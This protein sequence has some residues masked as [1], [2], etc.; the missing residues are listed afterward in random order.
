V[1]VHDRDYENK[2]PQPVTLWPAD[3]HPTTPRSWGE[4]SFGLPPAGPIAGKPGGSVK[5][6]QG[7]KGAQVPD[8]SVGGYTTCGEPMNFWK[9]WGDKA[10][11]SADDNVF[12]NIQ[13]QRD[14]A[15][16]PCFSKY[17]ITFPLDQVPAGKTILSATLTLHQIGNAGGWGVPTDPTRSLIQV[18]TVAEDW[19]P[20]T[21]SWN[22]APGPH[23]NVSRAWVTPLEDFPGWPGIPRDWDLTSTATHAYQTGQPL[24]LA[25]YSADGAYH[26]GKYFASSDIEAWGEASRPVLTITWGEVE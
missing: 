21:L 22:S 25:L 1:A 17:Y 11:T 3:M 9:E 20:A 26:S 16:F 10:Y 8:G 12:I 19:D 24:R 6:R 5:I 15:D 14:V 2:D 7:L 13:N 23:E 4:I 18:F